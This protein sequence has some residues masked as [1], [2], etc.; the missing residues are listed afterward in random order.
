M[1][2][3]RRCILDIQFH[4]TFKGAELVLSGGEITSLYGLPSGE[5]GVEIM[6]VLELTFAIAP[7]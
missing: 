5:S 7:A 1:L 4:G 3:C 6:P 2:F